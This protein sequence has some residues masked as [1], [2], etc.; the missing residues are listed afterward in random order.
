[1]VMAVAPLR[2]ATWNV[3][4][5]RDDHDALVAVLRALDP[6]LLA[7]QEAPAHWRGA[8]RW[9]RMLRDTG[10]FAP[11]RPAVGRHTVV[12]T[13]PRVRVVQAWDVPLPRTPGHHHRNALLVRA[14]WDD[15]LL[16]FGA[17]HLG[18]DAAERRR[19]AQWVRDLASSGGEPSVL[20]GDLNESPDGPAGQ[21]LAAGGRMHVLAPA[22]TFPA[23]APRHRIDA[24]VVDDALAATMLPLP[25]EAARL[26]AQ[27][28]D[29][30]PILV[31]VQ[32]RHDDA[33][34]G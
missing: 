19:H 14:R 25:P 3:H 33:T 5:L 28:S 7:V 26:V 15:L 2:L 1:M 32:A 21:M 23:S 17:V 12:L 16:R 30:V 34:P 31:E 8:R 24:V 11:V 27:A 4:G 6:D 18:L 10:L 20:A 29:H 13:G 9:R 22:A